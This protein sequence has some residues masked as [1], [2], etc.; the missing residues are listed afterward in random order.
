MKLRFRLPNLTLSRQL[1]LRLGVIVT[2]LL[3]M[4]IAGIAQLRRADARIESLVD[5]SLEP[6][7]HAGRIQ[8]DYNSSLQALTHA[9]LS[10]L[11]SAV[12]EART[13]I[14]ADRVDV[15]RHW[16][17]L[18]DSGLAEREGDT[19][20]LAATHRA[21]AD[22][23][24]D[25]TLDLL[26]AGQFELAALKLST[27]V[28][29]AYQ[30]L[31]SDFANLFE[32]ALV[33]G[34]A[35]V[36]KQREADRAGMILLAVLLLLALAAAI[37][38]DTLLSRSLMGRVRAARHAAS[39]IAEGELGHAI[40]VGANDE[41]GGLLRALSA[42]DTQLV[43]VLARVRDSAQSVDDRARRLADD[44][45]ALRQRTDVQAQ[46][47]LRMADSM[48]GIRSVVEEGARH[49]MSAT[50]AMHASTDQVALAHRVS[51]Q[52]QASMLDVTS[53]GRD[54]AEIVDLVDHIAFQ[55]HLLSLNAAIEAVHA[56]ESGRGF[57]VVAHEVR[58]LA[59]RSKEAGRDIRRMVEASG[60]AADAARTSVASSGTSLDAIVESIQSLHGVITRIQSSGAEQSTSIGRVVRAVDEIQV[61][62]R[63]NADLVG[64]INDT[65][66]ALAGDAR[67][68]LGQVA[69]FRLPEETRANASR[70][71]EAPSSVMLME[72]CTSS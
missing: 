32:S 47:L 20:K 12:E 3:V 31:Q 72:P 8:N 15:Q 41:L 69:Y 44:N 25:E 19:L 4:S 46:E 23:T 52:A 27:E 51:G 62:T 57:A 7:A 22:K 21:E 18:L 2:L 10:Q 70:E 11:P 38:L 45:H 60:D 1:L 53:T 5:G 56:G 29:P 49:V 39:R 50:Q 64:S 28:Q 67:T 26:D 24:V 35:L 54:I 42:M 59:S 43:G 16:K 9:V 66:R 36:Q 58:E 65:G 14:H 63:A 33:S 40:E 68:L 6:A 48:H 37:V 61:L 17:P 55:T 71:H 34:K 13:R 30:P